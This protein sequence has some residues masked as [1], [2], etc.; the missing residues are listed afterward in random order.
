[1]CRNA[2]IGNSLLFGTYKFQIGEKSSV[3]NLQFIN[4][5]LLDTFSVIAFLKMSF[6]ELQP[7]VLFFL[8]FR[9]CRLSFRQYR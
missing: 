6:I 2:S 3:F 9:L 7:L 4:F 5:K 8:V 1:M